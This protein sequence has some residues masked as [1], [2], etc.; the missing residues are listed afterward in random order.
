MSV[1]KVGL[2]EIVEFI[3]GMGISESHDLGVVM[4]HVGVDGAG[5]KCMALSTTNGDGAIIR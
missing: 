1:T 2:E 5:N 4:I 3:A